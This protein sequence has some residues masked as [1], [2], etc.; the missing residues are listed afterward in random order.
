MTFKDAELRQLQG[1]FHT[2]QTPRCYMTTPALAFYVQHIIIPYIDFF[3][4]PFQQSRFKN[5]I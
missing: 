1:E 2:F 4:N 5:F 3:A